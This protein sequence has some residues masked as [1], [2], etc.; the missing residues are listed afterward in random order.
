M[1]CPLCGANEFDPAFVKDGYTLVHCRE[2]GLVWVSN[3]PTQ[4]ELGR[5]YSFASGYGIE[6]NATRARLKT[7][8]AR[9]VDLLAG[10]RTPGRLLDLGCGVGYFVEAAQNAGWDAEGLDLN[11]G[12]VERARSR[13][14][15]VREGWIEEMTL[16][17]DAYDAVT[18]WDALEHLRDPRAT[19][20][21]AVSVLRPGGTLALSTPNID[22]LYPRL[23]YPLGRLTGYWTHPEP[24][25]HLVQFS[26]ATVVRLLEDAGLHVDTVAHE[27]SPLK[28]TLAPGG[29]RR[30]ARSPG[31]LA[32]AAVFLPFLLIGPHV[33]LG[34]EISV[35]ATREP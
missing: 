28:Y 32:Y 3:P 5:F 7:I 26:E 1:N 25:A 29:L 2:C 11:E 21:T 10:H 33:R 17:Q 6:D 31:R 16:E 4:E 35:V 27:R 9:H 18:M 20:E 23:S 19:I 30:L 14:L 13:G 15:S 24:P 12:V 22:G 34:D 8:A